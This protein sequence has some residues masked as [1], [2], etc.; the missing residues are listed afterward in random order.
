MDALH[1][2]LKE[3]S[4]RVQRGWS[5][6]EKEGY[7]ALP[8]SGRT[9]SES[10]LPRYILPL[11]ALLAVACFA[12]SPSSAYL[13]SPSFLSSA[14]NLFSAP[15][16]TRVGPRHFHSL[17]HG[18]GCNSSELI[19]AVAR[20]RIREDGPSRGNYT[21]PEGMD[22]NAFDLDAFSFSFD[23]DGCPAPHIFT[24]AEACD[25]VSAFGGIYNRGDS[26]MRQ[27]TQGL[28]LLLANSFDLVYDHKDECAGDAL[29]TNGRSCKSHSMFTSLDFAHVCQEQPFVMYD[30]VWKFVSDVGGS[31]DEPD[32]LVT[33]LL[34]KY[35]QFVDALP[36][37]RRQYSPI[38]VHATGIHYW[39]RTPQTLDVHLLPFLA[40]ASAAEPRPLAFFSGYPAVPS[41]KPARYAKK[42]SKANTQRYND[43]I[44]AVLPEISP[45]EIYEGAW[46]M[47]EWYNVTDGALSFDGTHYAYQ[48]AM[49][50]AQ[51]FLNVL[52]TVW[53]EVVSHG[54]LVE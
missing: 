25:L 22:R 38:F 24:P 40:N 10:S 54:G 30:Q 19:A 34:E 11:L 14:H 5:G 51:I 17:Y 35:H 46:R 44:R 48:V 26:L 29:F 9:S 16:A 39:W 28:F 3:L 47:L 21:Q 41:N 53:G 8:L 15:P 52:D 23:V 20:S 32:D 4:T 43:E 13:S 42:Q 31:K 27:F 37:R 1:T 50:R 6:G 33:P 49:E 45:G 18:R 12:Y 7:S 2:T 36:A